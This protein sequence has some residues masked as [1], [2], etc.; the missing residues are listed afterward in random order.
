MFNAICILVSI[1]AIYLIV[2]SVKN[3]IEI[4]KRSNLNSKEEQPTVVDNS[5]EK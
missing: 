4:F 3:V 2:D 1:L 5:D